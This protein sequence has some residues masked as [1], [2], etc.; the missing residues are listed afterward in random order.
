[1]I[2]LEMLNQK[3]SCG[4]LH[5]RILEISALLF[6]QP[7]PRSPCLHT[8]VHAYVVQT[9]RESYLPQFQVIFFHLAQE[10]LEY[11]ERV[12]NP[13]DNCQKCPPISGS[14]PYY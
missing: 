9:Y 3:H 8:Q 1:M 11:N 2:Y 4:R 10:L 5:L 14:N 7:P 6:G 12:L 13:A